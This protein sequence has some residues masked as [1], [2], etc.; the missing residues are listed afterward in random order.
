MITGLTTKLNLDEQGSE[1]MHEGATV[2]DQF[3][4]LQVP[5]GADDTEVRLKMNHLKAN[6]I[7][8][9]WIMF[10]TYVKIVLLNAS[11]ECFKIKYKYLNLLTLVFQMKCVFSS[12][13][14]LNDISSD[15]LYSSSSFFQPSC[16][17]DYA[18]VTNHSPSYVPWVN[19]SI[20]LSLS[21]L[22]LTWG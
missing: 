1:A 20:A 14:S 18:W 10:Q 12:F 8:V 19:F 16:S 17:L 11:I 9:Y 3:S 6:F 5:V 13:F 21:F 22:I 7:C 4:C 15:F 2:K